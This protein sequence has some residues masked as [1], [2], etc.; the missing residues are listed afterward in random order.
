[1]PARSW[2]MEVSWVSFEDQDDELIGAAAAAAGLPTLPCR[3]PAG[4][5]SFA[6][7]LGEKEH[8]PRDRPVGLE[9][10]CVAAASAAERVVVVSPVFSWPLVEEVESR[11]GV[12]AMPINPQTGLLRSDLRDLADVLGMR[13]VE[14]ID[15]VC[16][17]T[18][19]I[20]LMSDDRWGP[21]EPAGADELVGWGR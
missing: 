12:I 11:L 18:S 20:S 6:V 9:G 16:T 7:V 10:V 13:F 1:M 21:I 8:D 3:G 4:L 5:G 15:E 2:L 19:S 17:R 14:S